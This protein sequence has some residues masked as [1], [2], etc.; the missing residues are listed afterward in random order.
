MFFSKGRYAKGRRAAK[1]YFALPAV[2]ILLCQLV[3]PGFALAGGMGS[4]VAAP[5]AGG[6][7]SSQGAPSPAGGNQAQSNTAVSLSKAISIV[8]DNFSVPQE[9]TQFSSG[10]SMYNQSQTWSLNWSSP[11][12]PGGQFSAQV[13][14]N[15]GEILNMN[16]WKANNKPGPSLQIPKIQADAAQAI[17]QKLVQRLAGSKLAELRL[18]P[19][20]D[21]VIPLNRYG[22]VSYTVGWQR[23]VNGI[24]FPGNG[25]YVQVNAL[26]GDIQSYSLNWAPLSGI[27]A[28]TGVISQSK[29]E[30]R[31]LKNPMFELQYF[32]P[33]PFRPLAA[34]QKTVVQLVYQLNNAYQ[35]GAIDA[36]TGEPL[37]AQ[38]PGVYPYG[39]G[40]FGG[41][42]RAGFAGSFPVP[43]TPSE[44]SAVDKNAKLISQ[45][46]AVAAVKRWVS[47]PDSLVLRGS[48]LS[49]DNMFGGNPVWN[50]SWMGDKTQIP[51]QYM[52]ARVDAV[53]GELLGFN[54]PYPGP[55][56]GKPVLDRTGALAVAENFIK[57]IEP[58][59]FAELKLAGAAFPGGPGGP[60]IA[61][62]VQ[63]FNYDRLVN[64]IPY[65]ANG[66]NITVDTVSKQIINYNFNWAKLN[67]PAVTGILTSQQVS[68][69]F[70]KAE[71]LKLVYTQVFQPGSANNKPEIRLV[72]QPMPASG[73]LASAMMD[74][75][76]GE[77]LDWNGQPVS[78]MPGAHHFTDIA[79]S[80][81]SKEIALLGQA[82]VFGEYGNL[83]HPN[84]PITAGSL[85]K[86][87]LFLK[88][89]YGGPMPYNAATD[90]DVIKTA[91]QQGWLKQDLQPGAT[92]TRE[93]FTKWMIRYLNLEPVAQLQGIYKAPYSDVSKDFTGYAA[94]A[95]GMGMFNISGDT[96]DPSHGMTRAEAAYGLVKALVLG[97]SGS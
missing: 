54:L 92:V 77:F 95:K 26:N 90:Q 12:Q 39:K 47:I 84:E 35:G 36:L 96:F 75:K 49:T 15:T 29:A 73:T 9:Y 51:P 88:N 67:F 76:T 31:F 40:G 21:N 27:P 30:A 14:A 97:Q 83:F 71:P 56:A 25:V 59:H 48:N 37:K 33:P 86:A 78:E 44:Q 6:A 22:P 80:F 10:L 43:L 41:M 89:G 64:G 63:V 85:F 61:S 65:R 5:P 7:P 24:P 79:N 93:E 57:K 55:G 20:N 13:D 23:L 16:N 70:L 52:S 72:Y 66:I 17:A 32:T 11:D 1:R 69:D 91:Q 28:A 60:E 8:K 19:M 87:M 74:A 53:T 81:A 62:G 34:G 82:G 3:F 68:E 2:A 94:L 18:M 38:Y 58:G 50:L 42:Q 4:I 45:D 46:E